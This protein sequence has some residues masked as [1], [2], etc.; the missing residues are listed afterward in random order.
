MVLL[1][2]L[3]GMLDAEVLF[4]KEKNG[5]QDVGQPPGEDVPG[6]PVHHGHEVEKTLTP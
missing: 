4:C 2:S 6:G 1:L 5:C 3:R